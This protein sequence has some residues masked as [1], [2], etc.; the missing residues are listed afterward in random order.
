MNLPGRAAEHLAVRAELLHDTYTEV[1][2]RLPGNAQVAFGDDG[3]LL[4]CT[5][6]RWSIDWLCLW[7]GNPDAR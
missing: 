3:R 1:A 2:G 5:S 4:I 7:L 6:L